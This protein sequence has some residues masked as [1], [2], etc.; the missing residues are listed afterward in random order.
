MSRELYERWL[1][2]AGAHSSAIALQDVKTGRAWTFRELAATAAEI[3]PGTTTVRFATGDSVDF[4]FETLAAWRD[5]VVLCPVERGVAPPDLQNF[6]PGEHPEVSH[7]K[8]TSGST[9]KPRV[10]L[11]TGKQLAADLDKIVSTMGLS[12]DS[13][14][15]GVI[16]LAHSYGF[17]SLVLPLLLAGIPLVWLGDPLPSAVEKTLATGTNWTFPAV[18]AM[19]RAWHRAGILSERSIKIAIS[20]G[21]PLPNELEREIFEQVGLKVHN[22]YGS[23]ECGGIAYDRSDHPRTGS[24]IGEVMDAT[25]TKVNQEG[26]LVV[27]SD[28]VASGYHPPVDGIL[29]EREFATMDLARLEGDLIFLEG[30]DGDRINVAGRKISPERIE[31]VLTQLREITHV[32]V[33]GVPSEDATR[34]EE[35]V[36]VVNTSLDE[37]AIRRAI[38]ASLANWE[39]PRHWWFTPELE[40]DRRG[41]LSRAKWRKRWL[42][43]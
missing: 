21:A 14:N 15:L 26:C 16:S 13:P 20:A 8:L 10:V 4:I 2:T 19:W 9:G 35:I 31:Q 30:R 22:F 34:V 7:L 24:E 23:S 43:M 11:F 41:K 37:S 12:T 29:T 36:A 18:P 6:Q 27:R 42:D 17:S 39:Q 40:P 25:T 5:G 28:S 38:G 1:A 3:S 32:I 33:F